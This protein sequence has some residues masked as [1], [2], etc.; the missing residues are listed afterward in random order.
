[1]S[2]HNHLD[3]RQVLGATAAA[4]T[5]SLFTRPRQGRQ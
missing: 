1:M 3:R 5:T 2:E 4:F